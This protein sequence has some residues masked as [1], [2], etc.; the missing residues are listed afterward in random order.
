MYLYVFPLAP[1]HH[2][3]SVYR[4][5]TLRAICERNRTIPNVLKAQTINH[6]KWQSD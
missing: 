6:M 2:T 3:A 5:V 4:S 1:N